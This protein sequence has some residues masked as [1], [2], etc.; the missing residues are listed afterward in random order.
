[1]TKDRINKPQQQQTIS[2][3]HCNNHQQHQVI[4]CSHNVQQQ[5]QRCAVTSRNKQLN[6]TCTTSYS[7]FTPPSLSLLFSRQLF[8]SFALHVFFLLSDRQRPQNHLPL[9]LVLRPTHPK[10]NHSIG[11]CG[12][13]CKTMSYIN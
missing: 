11:H 7:S 13:S 5:Q 2:T 9:G 4:P 8:P 1:M 3:S 12:S 6:V 10:W